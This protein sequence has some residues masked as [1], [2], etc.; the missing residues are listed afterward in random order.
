RNFILMRLP[1]REQTRLYEVYWTKIE[2]LF[3]GSEK[4]FDSFVRDYIALRT[5]A[6]KQDK[7]DEIYFAFRRHFGSLGSDAN[8]LDSFLK[9]LLRFAEYHAAFSIGAD[10]PEALREPLARLR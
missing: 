8:N 10:A 3:R 9:E 1:E 5:E 2:N 6:S 7:A 4:T